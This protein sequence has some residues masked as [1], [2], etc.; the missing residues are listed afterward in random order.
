LD[1]IL[2]KKGFNS[3]WKNWINGCLRTTNFFVLTNRKP[4]GKFGAIRGLRQRNP[5]SS[6]LFILVVDVLS[7]LTEKAK[8]STIIEGIF[9]YRND[10]HNINERHQT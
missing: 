8:G 9:F 7:R 10:K 2:E 1:F 6:F 5:L 4:R 3:R